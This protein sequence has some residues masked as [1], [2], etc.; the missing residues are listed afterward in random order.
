MLKIGIQL[1]NDILCWAW[2]QI[3]Y[4]RWPNPPKPQ[5]GTIN[6]L[7]VWMCSWCT[8]NHAR[9]LKFGIHLKN[10]IVCWCMMSNLI[11]NM[12]KSPQTPVRNFQ[13][14]PSKTV[15]LTHLILMLVW[16]KDLSKI[17]S[18]LCSYQWKIWGEDGGGG[19][20]RECVPW[21]CQALAPPLRLVCLRLT[22]NDISTHQGII[23]Y[24]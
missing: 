20:T 8:Y 13:C 18:M 7:Q 15:F 22:A 16:R 1:K 4:Q 2:C 17:V 14:P 3:W 5:S 12:S 19:V 11:L 9:E 24:K 6:I 10:D 23:V 21:F